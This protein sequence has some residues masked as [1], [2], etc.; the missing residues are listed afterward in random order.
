MALEL[1]DQLAGRYSPEAD[2][3]LTAA[4]GEDLA[5]GREGDTWHASR[6]IAEFAEKRAGPGVPQ[7]DDALF[8]SQDQQP[9]VRRVLGGQ[10]P[11]MRLGAW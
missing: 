1:T 5:V 9:A 7:I 6:F 2:C 8:A 11:T 4:G 10:D 3:A